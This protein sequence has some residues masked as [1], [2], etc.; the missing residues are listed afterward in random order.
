MTERPTRR[1]DALRNREAIR[2]AARDLVIDRGPGIGMDEIASAAGVAVGTLY[3]HFPTKKDLIDAIVADLAAVIGR[4]LDA[5]LARVA[6]GAGSAIEELVA[7]L[8][9]VVIDM[10]QE[11]LLRFAVTGLAE[12]A[13]HEIQQRGR[14]ALEQ[15]VAAAHRDS[16]LYP[17]IT[18]DDVILL[19]ATAPGDDVS[20]AGQLRWLTLARRALTPAAER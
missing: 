6:D 18:V 2:A 17:D 20:A 14:D 19:L 3:R 16:A 7:L 9:A 13:L 11:R 15:I 5:A 1:A 10:R 8:Q 12:D 4:S